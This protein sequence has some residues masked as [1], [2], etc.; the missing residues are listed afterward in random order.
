MISIKI[1]S[2]YIVI[3]S[4]L[5]SQLDY[6]HTHIYYNIFPHFKMDLIQPK[7]QFQQLIRLICIIIIFLLL[8]HHIT[9]LAF[10]VLRKINSV[11][12][13]SIENGALFF[14]KCFFFSFH[15]DG[16]FDCAIQTR[17]Y[18]YVYIIHES[19]EFSSSADIVAW[20]L[21]CLT[22]LLFP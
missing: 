5:S 16:F 22:C 6:L 14:G 10:L 7:N 9:S 11:E 4:S 1:E 13:H 17:Q 20:T 19:S 15:C 21:N 2:E 12:I 8:Y 3:V 18:N